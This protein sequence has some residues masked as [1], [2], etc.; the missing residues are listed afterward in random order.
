MA[1]LGI[2]GGWSPQSA[3]L[4]SGQMQ[5]QVVS[6]PPVNLALHG[7]DGGYFSCVLLAPQAGIVARLHQ[8]HAHRHAIAVKGNLAREHCADV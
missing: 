2:L 8:F 7:C 3:S 6:D 1:G 5:S 4:S